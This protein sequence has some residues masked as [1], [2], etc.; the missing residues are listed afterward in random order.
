MS[1]T[2]HL[3]PDVWAYFPDAE[4][5]N[6]ARRGLIARIPAQRRATRQQKGQAFD[7]RVVF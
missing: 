7:S 4:S 3:D 6:V 1:G 2:V 5:V